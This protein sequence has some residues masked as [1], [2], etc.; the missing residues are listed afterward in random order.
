MPEW[1]LLVVL[2]FEVLRLG[3]IFHDSTCLSTLNHFVSR[4][5]GAYQK[6]TK[7]KKK[8]TSKKTHNQK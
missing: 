6:K 8:Q 7:K 5:D 4:K 2:F 3:S 1:S